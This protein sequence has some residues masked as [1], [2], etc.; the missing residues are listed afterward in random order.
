MYKKLVLGV[1]ALVSTVIF[2]SVLTQMTNASI[3]LESVSYIVAEEGNTIITRT[4][5]VGETVPTRTPVADPGTIPTRT[6]SPDGGCIVFAHFNDFDAG[7]ADILIRIGGLEV[8]EIAYG[9]VTNC[10]NVPPGS[11]L[12]EVIALN[13]VRAPE[14]TLIS[15]ANVSISTGAEYT[16]ILTGDGSANQPDG[17]SF[18]INS[19]TAPGPNKARVRVVH[20]APIDSVP[21]NTRVD[22]RDNGS[23]VVIGGVSNLTFGGVSGVFE[24]DAN[25][26]NDWYV[27]AA[28][29]AGSLIDLAPFTLLSGEEITVYISGGGANRPVSAD[30]L[31]NVE[32][33]FLPII[34]RDYTP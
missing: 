15:F 1:F 6:P 32:S 19:T 11:Y 10:I 34:S 29:S 25:V 28:G 20:A 7:D 23:G 9:D 16:A 31:T 3:G 24:V 13:G 26:A 5:T 30:I 4:P 18:V 33:E 8:A 17:I 12:L 27:S 2:A 21:F 14:D 22:L